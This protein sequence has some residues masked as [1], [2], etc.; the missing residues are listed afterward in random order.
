MQ[1]KTGTMLCQ[2]FIRT[3]LKGNKKDTELLSIFFNL[4]KLLEKKSLNHWHIHSF[5]NYMK[6]KINPFGL[7]VQIFQTVENI[8]PSFKKEWEKNL[9]MCSNGMMSLLIEEYQKTIREIDRELEPLYVQLTAFKN[10][11]SYIKYDNEL[12]EHLEQF[13][14]DILVKKEKKFLR[15]QNAFQEQ[16]AYNY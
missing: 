12:N 11:A 14:R 15:D 10:H 6:S 9:S 3:L 2:I 7:Q 16:K 4:K 5:E 13:N 1:A 8:G